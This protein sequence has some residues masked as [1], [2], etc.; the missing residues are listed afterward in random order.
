MHITVISEALAAAKKLV[1]HFRHSALATAALRMSVE[2]E[3]LQQACITRWNS[4]LYK[5]QS[6]LH[7]RCP[8]AAVLADASVTK[9]QY[10]HLELSPVHWI[11]L[12]DLS[13]VLEHLE[14]ATVFLSEENNV[15]ISCVLP[16]VHGLITKLEVVHDDSSSIKEF[17]TKV[18][19]ALQQRWGVNY[20][21]SN[22]ILVLACAIDPRF[23]NLRFLSDEQKEDVR[24]EITRLS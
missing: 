1:T 24:L 11:I 7:N 16:I 15:S 22:E 9:H 3:K 12:E 20:L 8:I 19:A 17:K 21:N 23:R 6:L 18:S 2:P 4:T 13:K 5:I 10:R 14:V